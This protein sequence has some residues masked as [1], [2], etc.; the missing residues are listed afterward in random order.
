MLGFIIMMLV[1]SSL[2]GDQRGQENARKILRGLIT[3]I[4]VI[5]GIRIILYTGFTLI[6]LIII[7]WAVMN[8]LVPFIRGFISSFERK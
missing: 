7:G 4:A 6:P 5:Y 8:I 1:I 3:M 2:M